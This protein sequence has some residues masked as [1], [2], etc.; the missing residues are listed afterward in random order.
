MLG[1]RRRASTRTGF[2][3]AFGAEL[4]AGWR[5]LAG[6]TVGLAFGIGCYTPVSSLFFRALEREFG[7]SKTTAV[8]SLV[9]LPIT[10][11]LLPTVGSLVDRFGVRSSA[12]VSALAMSAC[13]LWLSEM[14]GNV[15][16]F[17]AAFI[18]LNV[19]GAATGPITYTRTVAIRF[20]RARGTALALALTGISIAAMAFPPA[21]YAVL[22]HLGWRWGYR[23]LAATACA[24]AVVAIAL[25]RSD[26]CCTARGTGSSSTSLSSVVCTRAFW[27]LA[28][29][30]FCTSAGSIGLVSQFQSVMI[31]AGLPAVHAALLLSVMS[32]SVCLSRVAVGSA[33]DIFRPERI[34]AIALG[35]A[36]L[37]AAM[38]MASHGSFGHA[39]IAVLL[40]GLSIGTELDVLS[41][42]CARSFGLDHF[43]AA[44]GALS[45]FFYTGM[46]A[47][48]LL[49]A[50]LYDL[51]GSYFAPLA[52]TTVLFLLSAM[53]F[54]RLGTPS[55]KRLN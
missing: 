26:T 31:A 18:C 41:F 9:A 20:H 34:A 3:T 27:L 4:R 32:A 55:F 35:L 53:G 42:F 52:I 51:T 5:E 48:G 21:A 39:A 36:A 17:Y 25:V 45:V 7:W 33:L 29:A 22:S 49:Y 14:R 40:I 47:G 10:A 15:F 16:I 23:L 11:L 37:G 43:S 38:L 30:I 13:F 46:A 28:T 6:A 54:L 50:S 12:A 1:R 19:F 24:G 44:Y 8:A 2:V